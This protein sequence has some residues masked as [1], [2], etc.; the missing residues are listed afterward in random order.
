MKAGDLRPGNAIRMDGK[1]FVVHSIEHRTPGNL[2]A[3]VQLKIKDILAGNLL[4]RRM[5]PAED[6]ESVDLDRRTMEYLFSDTDGATFMDLDD[7]DQVIL[8]KS[9]LGDALLYLA[10]NS[11]TTVLMLEGNPVLIELPASVEVT[12]TD[13]APGIKGA[14]ATN[15]LKEAVC[16]TGLKTRVP[17]FI[18]NG[19]RIKVSTADGSY[20]SRV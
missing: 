8:S 4:E 5:N 9:I 17:P 16:D 20:M 19:E 6:V 14:T 15:Q 7:Y 3:F 10:P 2:R 1:V 12:V 18:E 11:S 13:T